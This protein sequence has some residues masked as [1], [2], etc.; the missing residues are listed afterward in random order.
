MLYKYW[1]HSWGE[2]TK[3]DVTD[4]L[5]FLVEIFVYSPPRPRDF[6]LLVQ[7]YSAICRPS[8]ALWG[9]PAPGRYSNPGGLEAG[10]LTARPPHL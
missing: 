8:D 7:Y 9:G 6:T 4:A 1:L 3:C 2:K 10:T 5:Q